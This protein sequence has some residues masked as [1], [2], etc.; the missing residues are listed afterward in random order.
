MRF[1]N[2][3]FRNLQ[4]GKANKFNHFFG[5]NRD[6]NRDPLLIIGIAIFSLPSKMKKK[7]HR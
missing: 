4:F 1:L 7:N 5:E 6:P 2:R 3:Q